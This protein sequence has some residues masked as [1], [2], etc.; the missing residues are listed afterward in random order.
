MIEKTE[1]VE[2]HARDYA[3]IG[4]SVGAFYTRMRAAGVPADEARYFTSDVLD[5]L[6]DHQTKGREKG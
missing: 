1:I 6:L 5:K 3:V 4:A 2:E